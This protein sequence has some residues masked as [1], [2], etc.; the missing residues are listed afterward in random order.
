MSRRKR[1]PEK[2]VG[3]E[4]PTDVAPSGGTPARARVSGKPPAGAAPGERG[5]E[6]SRPGGLTDFAILVAVFVVVTGIAELAGAANLGVAIGIGQVAFA[7]ALVAVLL[8]D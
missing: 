1:R 3:G 4:P 2:A 8:R 7:I 5:P 6:R